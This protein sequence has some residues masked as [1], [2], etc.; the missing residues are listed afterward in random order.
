VRGDEGAVTAE[1][2][3]AMPTV[4]LLLITCLS[5][6]GMTTTLHRAHDAAASSARLLARGETATQAAEH[7]RTVLTGAQLSVERPGD[8]VCSRVT[9]HAPLLGRAVALTARACALDGGH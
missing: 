2:A 6:V 9:A 5:A 7:V 8:L 1:V 4:V 3:V